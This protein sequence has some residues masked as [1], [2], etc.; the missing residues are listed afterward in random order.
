MFVSSSLLPQSHL[1]FFLTRG[2]K[3][4]WMQREKR[5]GC[6]EKKRWRVNW[7]EAHWS[8]RPSEDPEPRE[9]PLPHVSSPQRLCCVSF[10]QTSSS[11]ALWW[12]TLRLKRARAHALSATGGFRET[13]SNVHTPYRP[14]SKACH[15]LYCSSISLSCWR[16]TSGGFLGLFFKTAKGSKAELMTIK[17]CLELSINSR[18]CSPLRTRCKR[19]RQQ[20][21]VKQEILLSRF[22]FLTIF[23]CLCL[24]LNV[25]Q[26][27]CF[28][29]GTSAGSQGV[30]EPLKASLQLCGRTFCLCQPAAVITGGCLLELCYFSKDLQAV[31][32]CLDSLSNWSEYRRGWSVP[33]AHCRFT[34][35]TLHGA[36]RGALWS[37]HP[38]RQLCECQSCL[39]SLSF[40]SVLFTQ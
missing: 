3:S 35:P 2:G 11:V 25:L 37:P 9:H 15:G 12:W 26:K 5:Q 16:L 22:L 18:K 24:F 39:F 7:G 34:A 33:A 4:R 13:I 20:N 27:K 19:K 30:L 23:G 36:L 17:Q 28:S 10:E 14:F 6:I 40:I 38:F 21:S 32:L 31:K 1:L 8:Q 29:S